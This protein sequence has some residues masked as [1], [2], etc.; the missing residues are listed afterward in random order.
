MDLS[1]DFLWERS[2]EMIWLM[3]V[4]ERPP[5]CCWGLLEVRLEVEELR[6]VVLRVDDRWFSK[7]TLAA[8]AL[9]VDMEWDVL[10][11]IS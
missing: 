7:L 1:G 2:G 11:R 9:E 8:L 3:G 10:R 4:V 5:P 6:V